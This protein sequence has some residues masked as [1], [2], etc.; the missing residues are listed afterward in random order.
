VPIGTYSLDKS[1]RGEGSSPSVPLSSPRDRRRQR[2]HLR[3]LLPL[4][5]SRNSSKIDVSERPRGHLFCAGTTAYQLGGQDVHVGTARIADL[6]CA[7]EHNSDLLRWPTGIRG[8]PRTGASTRQ[9]ATGWPSGGPT[10]AGSGGSTAASAG[11]SLS[12][13]TSGPAS[14]RGSAPTESTRARA[15]PRAITPRG[16][17]PTGRWSRCRHRERLVEGNTRTLQT[18][19]WQLEVCDLQSSV[20]DRIWRS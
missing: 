2:R 12:P 14:T 17:E 3:P 4:K 1:Y 15:G 5:S 13:S 7:T 10:R 16:R 6:F 8:R 19:N 11:G 9:R 20:S 18:R